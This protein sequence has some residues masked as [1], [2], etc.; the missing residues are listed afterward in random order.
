MSGQRTLIVPSRDPL[1]TPGIWS[2]AEMERLKKQATVIT[3]EQKMAMLE[4]EERKK[5]KLQQESDARKEMLKKAQVTKQNKQGS[6][7][8]EVC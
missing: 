4:E 5:I 6:K 2:K 7:L 3:M 1:E 8:H